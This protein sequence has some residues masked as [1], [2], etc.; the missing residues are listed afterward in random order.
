MFEGKYTY[1]LL[2]VLSLAYPLAQS[3]EHRITLVKKWKYIFPGIAFMAAVF[4][5]WDIYFTHKGYWGFNEEYTTGFYLA[6]LPFEEWLFFLIVPYCCFFVYF[7][8][9]YFLPLGE[10]RRWA[11]PVALLV[12]IGLIILGV[13][14]HQKAYSL[15]AF[16]GAGI[17]LILINFFSTPS[18]MG[19]FLFS[20]IVCLI[21]FLLVNGVLTAK[22]VVWYNDLENVGIR[23][24][25][26]SVARIPIEDTAYCL[27][28][29]I[30]STYVYERLSSKSA[31][32][33]LK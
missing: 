30:M 1:L 8:L 17:A 33:S 28:M 13:I 9:D 21:P 25:M 32:T 23:I 31:A 12:G 22:P 14:F 7:V 24:S 27:L 6:N 3:F 11:R 2:M 18:W 10:T 16:G 4:I 26:G 15:A 29:L 5:P 20:Y 19:K